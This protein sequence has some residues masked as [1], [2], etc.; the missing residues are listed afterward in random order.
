MQ[1][2]RDAIDDI[3]RALAEDPDSV[4][5]QELL[6][7]TYRDELNVMRRVDVISNYAMVRGDI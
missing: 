1:A 7:E 3:N 6:I 5:L 2:I 4:L